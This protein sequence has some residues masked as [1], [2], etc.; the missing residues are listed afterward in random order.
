M[1]GVI[2]HDLPSSHVVAVG[3]CTIPDHICLVEDADGNTR[4][5]IY[6][7]KAQKTIAEREVGGR[8]GSG[9]CAA[10]G[11]TFVFLRTQEPA[12]VW[13]FETDKIKVLLVLKRTW[14]TCPCFSSISPEGTRVTLSSDVHGGA[15]VY[16]LENG[17]CVAALGGDK[18]VCTAFGQ[19]EDLVYTFNNHS[20]RLDLWRVSTQ[21]AIWSRAIGGTVSVRIA[22]GMPH[23][24]IF[25]AKLDRAQQVLAQRSNDG[26]DDGG[27]DAGLLEDGDVRWIT[28]AGHTAIAW[29]AGERDVGICT[30]DGQRRLLDT[31]AKYTWTRNGPHGINRGGA[32]I[33]TN[34]AVVTF[35]KHQ[36]RVHSIS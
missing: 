18:P 34:Q 22:A 8:P 12:L 30:I 2:P 24:N 36:L 20:G 17:H 14:Q 32:I 27:D 6:D 3:N 23:N 1:S 7:L 31:P 28:S 15:A 33:V 9:W 16:D 4:M 10:A 35:Q 13:N 11:Q 25:F 5:S 26:G 21:E 29:T 19:D